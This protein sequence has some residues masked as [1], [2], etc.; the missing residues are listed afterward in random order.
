MSPP[1]QRHCR[2][3][4]HFAVNSETCGDA[5]VV[6]IR[7]EVRRGPDPPGGGRMLCGTQ[8]ADPAPAVPGGSEC[9]NTR[10]SRCTD[11]GGWVRATRDRMIL[12]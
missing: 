2:H 6:E 12:E 9:T 10:Q 7:D 1:T 3:E 11:H 4:L 5:H 8:D